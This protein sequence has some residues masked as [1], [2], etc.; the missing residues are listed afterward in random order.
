M[1]SKWSPVRRLTT[2]EYGVMLREK[3][4]ALEADIA[5]TNEE[6]EKLERLKKSKEDK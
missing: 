1:R 5:I 4:L 6:I 2:K 3:L